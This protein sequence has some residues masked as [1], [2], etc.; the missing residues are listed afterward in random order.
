MPIHRLLQKS[1]VLVTCVAIVTPAIQA[2]AV[3]QESAQKLLERGAFDEA[4][5]Q[6][7][8]ERGNPES[9][10]IAAQA[11]VR[12]SAN[13]RA[14]TEY[15]RLREAGAAD[16]AAIAESGEAMVSGDLAG[17]RAAAER[18]TA[19]NGAN[20]FAHY[21]KG[22]IAMR[23]SQFRDA[24]DA[25]S[26]TTGLRPDF[27]YA[28]YYAGIAHQRLREI[29]RMAEHFESFLKLAPKAPEAG[30]VM[31]ILRSLRG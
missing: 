11:L 12:L 26:Q 8:G 27:A 24:A 15:A 19:A 18:A 23:Q 10:F 25:F 9:A 20:P 17:A 7:D 28:H 13:D 14:R 29:P 5:Q 1:A 16:W 31:G 3:S 2:G 22:L 30:A 6:A 4:V 21:Q